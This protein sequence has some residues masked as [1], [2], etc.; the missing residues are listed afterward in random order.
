MIRVIDLETTGLP[1]DAEVVEAAYV[2]ITRDAAGK[3]FVAGVWRSFV[4]PGFPIPPEA[5]AIHHITDDMVAG[6]PEWPAVRGKLLSPN[7]VAYA[8][9]KATFEKSF[10]DTD[11]TPLLDIYKIALKLWP[12]C[13]KHSNQTV[14]YFLKLD[15]PHWG[16]F[17]PSITSGDEL[18][19]HRAAGDAIATAYIFMRALDMITP[20]EMGAVSR[21]PALLP[22]FHFGEHAGKPLANVPFSYLKWIVDRSNFSEADVLFTAEHELNRREAVD[23]ELKNG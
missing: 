17:G 1:P 4:D 14:R 16:Y 11:P 2:D 18:A 10:I 7:V 21:R 8:A 6:A 9:Y 23:R 12:E 5:S 22:R 3:P 19:P 13:P 20:T 15:L